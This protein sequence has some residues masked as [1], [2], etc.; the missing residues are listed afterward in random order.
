MLIICQ[1]VSVTFVFHS[2][3]YCAPYCFSP[4]QK[5]WMLTEMSLWSLFHYNVDFTVYFIIP[6][7]FV[8]GRN[9]CHKCDVLEVIALF[10][11]N[12]KK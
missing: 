1:C 8:D 9:K 5:I 12:K 7:Y 2:M 3:F 4:V 10:M 6:W 11:L